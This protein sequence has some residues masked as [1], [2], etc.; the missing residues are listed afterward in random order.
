MARE[1]GDVDLVPRIGLVEP[2]FPDLVRDPPA[3]AE[4][5]RPHVD[6]DELGVGHRSVGLL[7]Q[8]AGEAVPPSSMARV[9]P[10]V[11]IA[12]LTITPPCD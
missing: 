11:T 5:H 3:A 1:A 12:A 6:V 8:H 4:L 7:D 9:G 2:R 10:V